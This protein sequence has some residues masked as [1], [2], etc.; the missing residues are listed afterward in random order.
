MHTHATCAMSLPNRVRSAS[1][2]CCSVSLGTSRCKSARRNESS[3]YRLPVYGYVYVT[4]V[5]DTSTHAIGACLE[6]SMCMRHVY[7]TLGVCVCVCHVIGVCVMRH[8]Y[9]S[10]LRLMCAFKKLPPNK[11]HTDGSIACHCVRCHADD[12]D[13]DAAS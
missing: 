5:C 4:H 7:D 10:V 6:R 2:C 11:K 3:M 9:E 8:A 12:A 1:A 13:I